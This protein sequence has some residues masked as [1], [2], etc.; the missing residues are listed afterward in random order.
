MRK[1]RLLF[2]CI[3]FALLMSVVE[4]GFSQAQPETRSGCLMNGPSAGTFV[5][6]DEVTGIRTPVVDPVIGSNLGQYTANGGSRVTVTGTMTRQGTSDL[7]QINTVQQTQTACAPVGFSM[8]SLKQDIGRARFGV[9]G[10]VGFDPELV[11]VGGQAQLGPV[12]KGAWFRPTTEFS[13]GQ[14][15]KA[16]SINGDLVYYLPFTGIG[17]NQQNRWNTYIGG[18]PAFTLLRNDFDGFPNQD[19]SVQVDDDWDGDFGFNFVF[20]VLQTSG[21]FVELRASAYQTPDV[22][23]YIGYVFH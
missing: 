12:F 1:G 4:V 21:L 15:T 6:V 18:G 9:R 8:T 7:F 22:R 17:S 5:L 16:W 10:G 2:N 23:L 13:F 3:V 14:V 20:G 11:V 19:N